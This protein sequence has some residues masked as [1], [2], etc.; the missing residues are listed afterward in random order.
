[1]DKTL[2][3]P[4]TVAPPV[5]NYAHGVLVSGSQR[6]LFISGQIPA[7]PDGAIP[8]D[9]ESQARN[10]W[11]NIENILK[12]A[13][14]SFDNLVKTT[15]FLSDHKYLQANRQIRNEMIGDRKFASSAIVASTLLP[16][17]LLEIEAIAMA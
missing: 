15:I 14:M 11:R 16:E 7:G 2:I 17:W 10:C 13:G 1:M 5:G 9:F 12:E 8:K 3:N 6:M 4:T